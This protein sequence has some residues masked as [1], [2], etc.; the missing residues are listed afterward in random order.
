MVLLQD[1]KIPQEIITLLMAGLRMKLLPTPGILELIRLTPISHSTQN[2]FIH[3]L[4]PAVS[5][6]V[7]TR[8]F[9]RT[10]AMNM[11]NYSNTL[12]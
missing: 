3:T 8:L 1:Q 12:L 9:V 10:A 11:V 6:L 5:L 4:I 2:G 7:P